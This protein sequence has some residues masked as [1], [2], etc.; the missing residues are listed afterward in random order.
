MSGQATDN[1]P[2]SASG[3]VSG[4]NEKI[5]EYVVEQPT[6]TRETHEQ[7]AESLQ[8]GVKRAEMLRKGWTKKNLIM[9]FAG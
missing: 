2:V 6:H 8:E 9:A 5:Q 1:Q 3:P 7:D 4:D